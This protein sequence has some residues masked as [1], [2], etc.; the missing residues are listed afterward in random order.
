M[1]AHNLLPPASRQGRAEA[2]GLP[3]RLARLLVASRRFGPTL[4]GEA[5]IFWFILLAFQFLGYGGRPGGTN[6]PTWYLLLTFLMAYF[7][8]AAGETRFHLYRRVWT[9]AGINDAFAVGLAV[10]EATFL[11]GLANFMMGEVRPYRLLTPLLAAPAVVIAVGAFRLLPRLL[12]STA[13]AGSRLLVVVPD[14]AAYTTVKIL[15]QHANPDWV[16]VAIATLEPGDRGRTVMGVPVVG[17]AGALARWIPATQAEGVAFVL[18]GP[19]TQQHRD[20]FAICLAAGLPIFIVPEAQ[21]WFPGSS[22]VPLR[23]LSA[24][25]LVGRAQREIEIRASEDVVRGKTVL[26]TGAAGSIGSELCRVLAGLNPARLILLDINESGIYDLAE[27]LRAH[28]SV[29]VREA[30]VS[31]V[32]S[33][34]LRTVFAEE[35][36]EVVFHCAA[37]KHVPMLESHPIQAVMTN[38]IGT[39]NTLR[40]AEAAAVERFVLISTDKAVARHSVMGCTKRLCEEMVLG[41]Q[42]S[43]VSWAVRFGNVVGSRGSVVPLFERQIEQGGPVTI[44][45]PD[46]TRFMMTIGEAV[47][48]VVRTLPMGESGHLYMLDMGS[49]L[50]I[51]DLAHA[52]IRSRGMR[53]GADIEIVFSG[54]RPGELMSEELLAADEGV[55][56]TSDPSIL[57]VVAPYIPSESDLAWTIERVQTLAREGRSDELVR[58]LKKAVRNTSRPAEEPPIAKRPQR[59]RLSET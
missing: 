46:V 10:L 44:T 13:R 26:V 29:D 18:R 11:F 50:K 12:S 14:A 32:D 17:S 58:T 52:L 24:D 28:S 56:P 35:R 57:D 49:P 1:P 33:D 40:C 51:L 55:R 16:P 30:L 45:H 19:S 39:W 31:I 42:G 20:L 22:G 15:L 38:V 23:Q 36:P 21:K 43:T 48:L 54:L 3:S 47:L 27:E 37:Y 25:D 8:M 59:E 4:F 34:Q 6:G 9:V 5:L 2:V 53:P 41:H 7:A